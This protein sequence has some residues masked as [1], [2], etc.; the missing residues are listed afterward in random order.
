MQTTINGLTMYVKHID[1]S[2]A[3][4]VDEDEREHRITI[5]DFRALFP[6]KKKKSRNRNKQHT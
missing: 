6:F 3:L 2:I 5:Q 4:L 1:N